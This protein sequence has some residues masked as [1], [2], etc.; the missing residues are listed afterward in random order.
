MV[1]VGMAEDTAFGAYFGS[2]AALDALAASGPLAASGAPLLSRQPVGF[3]RPAETRMFG[4]LAP[5]PAAPAGPMNLSRSV[6]GSHRKLAGA[7]APPPRRPKTGD[8][9]LLD[10]ASRMESDGGMPGPDI[11]SRAIASIIA[12]MA[13]VSQGHTPSTGAFR[14][15]VARLL[16]FLKSLSGLSSRQQQL[17]AAAIESAEK[18]AAPAGDWL[19]MADKP[20]D[21]WKEVMKL[22]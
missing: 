3:A 22:L 15:H 1:P 2:L 7:K 4:A 12:L 5:P 11:A 9:L 13:F 8:D 14:S 10:L 18:G 17:V 20:G 16:K 6:F 19:G 21:R